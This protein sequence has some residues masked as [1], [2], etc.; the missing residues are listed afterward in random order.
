MSVCIALC[1]PLIQ[2][3]SVILSLLTNIFLWRFSRLDLH[4]VLKCNQEKPLWRVFVLKESLTLK[5]QM[6]KHFSVN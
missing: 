5:K 2:T 3:L 1:L 4:Q 6:E